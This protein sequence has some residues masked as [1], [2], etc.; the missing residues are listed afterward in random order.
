MISY[1]W[2]VPESFRW[3][4]VTGNVDRAVSILKRIAKVNRKTI[5]SNSIEAIK[6]R[7]STEIKTNYEKNEQSMKCSSVLHSFCMVF[8]SRILC[9]RFIICC[10][11]WI[12]CTFS[13][14][15]L[16]LSSTQIPGANRYISFILIVAIEVPAIL[17]TEPLLKRLK[18]KVLLIVSLLISSISIIVTPFLPDENATTVLI[19]W[20]MGKAGIT[21]A[22]TVVYI[23]TCEQWPTNLRN[24]IM[25]TCSMVG[26]IGSMMAP[27]M[28]IL[29]IK[30]I[31]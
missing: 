24:T 16:S 31:C 7:Y 28:A 10:Y 1:L 12:A 20:L 25:N 14:Y 30:T 2:L 6:L 22:F 21:I 11:Q 13:Y 4:L 5:S 15:G 8:K 18:R 29:V 3:L 26:R 17:I 27:M 19:C 23:F 9:L